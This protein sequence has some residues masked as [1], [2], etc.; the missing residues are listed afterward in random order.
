MD[1]VKRITSEHARNDP[2]FMEEPPREKELVDFYFHLLIY[3][4]APRVLLWQTDTN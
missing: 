2:Y 4:I 3:Y 1:P